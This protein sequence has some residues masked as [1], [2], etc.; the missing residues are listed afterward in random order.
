MLPICNTFFSR[1]FRSICCSI[2]SVAP[3]SIA[4]LRFLLVLSTALSSAPLHSFA[5]SPGREVGPGAI[6]S[7]RGPAKYV[8]ALGADVASIATKAD[9]RIDRLSRDTFHLR[10]DQGE[11]VTSK[12][13]FRAPP[14]RYSRKT[15]PCK[16]AKVRRLM[17]SMNV[18]ARCEPNW[19]YRATIAPNDPDY[20]LQYG[21]SFLSLPA[22]WDKTTGST[23]LVAVV[24][25]TGIQL[26]HPD[27][28]ANIWT[29]PAEI[30]GNSLDDDGNGYIDDIHGINT[31]TGNGAP[32]DDNGHGTHCAGILG[33]KG[34]NSAGIAG[35]SWNAKIVAAK[36]L[37]SSGSG[38]TSDAIEAIYYAIALKQAGNNV[39]VTNNSW[40]GGGYSAAL[41]TAIQ[42]AT[43]AEILFVA[44]AGNDTLNTDVYPSY[45]A[46]YNLDG[47]ISVASSN[48]SGNLSYFSNFGTT[49]VDIAAP[50][51][52]IRS[53]VPTNSYASYSGTS[54]AAPQVTGIAL[55]AQSIC[56]GTLTVAQLKA[57]ILNSGVTYP[58]LDGQIATGAIANADG[59]VTAA[60]T[61]C[62]GAPTATPTNTPENTPTETPNP[63][64]PT[65]TPQPEQPTPEPAK[66]ADPNAK[67][68]LTINPGSKLSPNDSIS[69]SVDNAGTSRQALVQLLG[70]DSNKRT[71]SCPPVTI[72]LTDGA[73]SISFLL[74]SSTRQ[75]SSISSLASADRKSARDTAS[76]ASPSRNR[77]FTSGQRAFKT[78]C[79]LLRKAAK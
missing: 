13:A 18:R 1:C 16:R 23:N 25:D 45:P 70:R 9:L 62:N 8:L 17:A 55:L 58:S 5:S 56:S 31:I 32:D 69:I 22:A 65:D 74:P 71:Y 4:P 12:S 46:S 47:I 44:A 63:P 6:I 33:A 36:F 19:A 7:V 61:T 60:D 76:V 72:K 27:L 30:A 64:E 24:I 10:F 3:L 68:T 54:M 28:A 52:L 11:L 66:G 50:G 40:G 42:Q 15:N 14:V 41:Y 2:S 78:L 29:N 43:A 53:C 35:V 59:A 51:S 37:D 77:N 38:Y 73:A 21:S 34:N 20:S 79:A 75:F 57:A 49:S 67:M 26:N 39:V 48:S